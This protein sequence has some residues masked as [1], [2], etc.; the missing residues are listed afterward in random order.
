MASA[1]W[2]SAS[3]MAEAAAAAAISAASLKSASVRVPGPDG[4]TAT[5]L[6]LS[7]SR[8]CVVGVCLVGSQKMGGP[9]L[10]R[11]N[12]WRD[13]RWAVHRRCCEAP[14]VSG[15]IGLSYRQ[16]RSHQIKRVL[17]PEQAPDLFELRLTCIPELRHRVS[18][19]QSAT[20]PHSPHTRGLT[21]FCLLRASA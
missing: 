4:G 10:V 9:V 8:R 5:T 13:A 7:S 12:D 1:R 17:G 14:S 18:T 2:V 11:M 3:A 21:S 19:K 16:H 6:R 20:H 15:M